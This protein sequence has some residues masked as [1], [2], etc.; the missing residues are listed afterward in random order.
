[1]TLDR[2]RQ[3]LAETIASRDFVNVLSKDLFL[4]TQ[5]ADACPF[6]VVLEHLCQG[7]SGGYHLSL[8][9]GGVN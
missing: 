9:R 6:L 5:D 1:M 3:S 7:G 2:I 4:H 8:F